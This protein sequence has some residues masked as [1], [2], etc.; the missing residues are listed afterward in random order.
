MTVTK[1]HEG[2][3][4]VGTNEV[5]K[6]KPENVG[7]SPTIAPTTVTDVLPAGLSFISADGGA[8]WT[9]QEAAGT[10]TCEH[11]GPISPEDDMAPI[12]IVTAV[13]IAAAP[14][15]TN[16]ASVATNSDFNPANNQSSDGGDVITVD[17]A[18][19]I[20]R[21]G[22]FN[23]GQTGTYLINVENAGAIAATDQ[24]VVETELGPG[25]TFD[26]ATGD[27]WS[28]NEN[29]GTVTCEGHNG[30][31]G[32]EVAPT[33]PVLVHVGTGAVP[34]TT[35][36]ARVTT[37]G[38]RFADNDE[39]V[40]TASVLGPDLTVLSSHAGSFRVGG[41]ATYE[42]AVTNVGPGPTTGPVIVTDELPTGFTF[43]RAQGSGWSC[44]DAGQIITCEREGVIAAGASAP[45]IT[46]E[47]AVGATALP[48][49]ETTATVENLVSVQTGSDIAAGNDQSGDMT[50]ISGTDLAVT[51]DGP[52]TI[53]IGGLATYELNIESNSVPNSGPIQV[54]VDLP[55][56][57]S[58]RSFEGDGWNCQQ[59]TRR[60]DCVTQA[61]LNENESAP[62]LK[63]TARIGEN[64][65]AN[66]MVKARVTA[67][68]DVIQ[69]NDQA[70]LIT[71]TSVSPELKAELAAV[72]PTGSFVV[73]SDG[74]YRAVLRNIGSASTSGTVSARLVLPEGFRFL[75][76]VAGS[77]WSCAGTGGAVSCESP[78]AIAAGSASTL[79]LRVEVTG[80]AGATAA[81]ELVIAAE[82]DLNEENDTA[83]TEN[84][85]RRIDLALERTHQAGWTAG[86]EGVYEVKVTNRGTAASIAAAVVSETL[87]PGTSF[88]LASGEGWD[89]S[90]SGRRLTCVGPSMIEPGT[91]TAFQVTHGLAGG[92]GTELDA[93][94][95]VKTNGDVEPANDTA[96]DTITVNPEGTI[97][98]GLPARLNTASTRATQSGLVLLRVSCPADS[99]VKCVGRVALRTS[100]KVKVNR[101]RRAIALGSTRFAVSPGRRSAIRIRLKSQGKAALK[102][103]G[104][105]KAR[106][107]VTTRG[108]DTTRRVLQIRRAGR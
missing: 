23:P 32:P 25:L 42:L 21:T 80:A 34:E 45:V 28:C 74:E 22:T 85:V 69:T 9:C 107:T 88:R 97:P 81:G 55:A 53:G 73:G 20:G 30:L 24:L 96:T 60:F 57:F 13:G 18:V 12:E 26:S 48:S 50:G 65:P 90:A 94:S 4:R 8:G 92:N 27:G 84:P 99:G 16:Q 70:S 49:G 101:S 47:A 71:T 17:A 36:V 58:A 108:A 75:G 102:Q 59:S 68:D 39:A 44:S 63:V 40:D 95:S 78:A 89:C 83:R 1:S 72:T 67:A 54:R 100:G 62:V 10:V 38:D 82:G 37:T 104:R 56:G 2:E 64:P 106:A 7:D 46:V 3:I 77:G 76:L 43:T 98:A 87:L 11:A 91:S 14:T 86:Q 6:L 61:V 15:V 79:G 5:F 33:S 29:A 105:L 52:A 35:T 51:L 19:V 93:T 31:D 41:S 103:Q 66:A